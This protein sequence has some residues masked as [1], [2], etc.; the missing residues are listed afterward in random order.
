MRR[1][2]SFFPFPSSIGF[3]GYGHAEGARH[4]QRPPG[5]P[6]VDPILD[7]D[8]EDKFVA[9]LCTE[10]LSLNEQ[11]MNDG[12]KDANSFTR[13]TPIFASPV[14][15]SLV[16]KESHSAV[17]GFKFWDEESILSTNAASGAND[18]NSSFCKTAAY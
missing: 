13:G 4:W 12:E 9:D 3:N 8:D 6:P 11:P 10:L 14:V 15:L 17:I 1:F 18:I 5:S 2:A 7:S 16:P